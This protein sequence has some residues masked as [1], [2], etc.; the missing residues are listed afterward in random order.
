MLVPSSTTRMTAEVANAHLRA[1]VPD[2]STVLIDEV[3]SLV[4][5]LFSGR[6]PDYQKADLQYH[7]LE[8]TLL[9]TQCYIDLAN[10]RIQHGGVPVF[11]PREFMLGYVAIML[12]DTGYLKTRADLGGT[13]AKYTSTHVVRSCAMAAALLP[14]LGCTDAEIEG[15]ANAIRCTGLTSRI[16]Q[17]VFRTDVERLTGCMVAT[18]DYLG[19]MADPGYPGKLAALFSEFEEANEFNGVPT[20][21]RTFRSVADLMAK[22]GGFWSHFTLPKLDR[23][24][25]GVYRCLALPDGSNPYLQAVEENLGV[26][27]ARAAT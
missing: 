1:I 4:E 8:H 18:A 16:E 6:H 21:Q 24:Y 3:S 19:Q 20:A 12:H 9:A 14:A 15:V 26:I 2:A 25:E 7:N 5:M 13:G 11:S 10:G 23:D 27:A 17:I 22:T